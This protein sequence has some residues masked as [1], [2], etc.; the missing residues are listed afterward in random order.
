[1]LVQE[2]EDG[3]GARVGAWGVQILHRV[4]EWS[5]QGLLQLDVG[6]RERGVKGNTRILTEMG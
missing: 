3:G 5:P 2:G 1:M 4:Y 6:V